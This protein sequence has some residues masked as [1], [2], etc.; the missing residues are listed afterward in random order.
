M[1]KPQ[2]NINKTNQ[3]KPNQTQMMYK[4]VSVVVWT[5]GMLS[6]AMIQYKELFSVEAE[7]LF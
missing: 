4:S 1:T 2:Q 3:T 7:S 5:R 6:F